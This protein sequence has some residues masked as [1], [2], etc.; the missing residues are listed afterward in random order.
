VCISKLKPNTQINKPLEKE[1]MKKF[2]LIITLTFFA[3]L[4]TSSSPQTPVRCSTCG[5]SGVV[6]VGYNYY[7][8]AV[9]N[10]CP[11]CGGRGYII[12]QQNNPSFQGNKLVRTDAKC[13][14]GGCRCSGYIGY[15]TSGGLYKGACQNSDG[16]GHTCGHSPKDHGLQGSL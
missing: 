10:Y 16:W 6:V 2:L 14:K 7:G 15:K 13:K 3:L 12:Y 11:T 9:T 4:T 1:S 5:G 8:G